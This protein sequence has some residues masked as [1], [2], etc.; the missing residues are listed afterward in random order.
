MITLSKALFLK[1]TSCESLFTSDVV[2]ESDLTC[3]KHL[4]CW[5]QN[6]VNNLAGNCCMPSKQVVK[7]FCTKSGEP[8]V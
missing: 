6:K 5:L 8:A 1:E 4:V 7:Q 2:I 3:H